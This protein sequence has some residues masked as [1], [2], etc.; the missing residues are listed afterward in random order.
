[1]LGISWRKWFRTPVKRSRKGGDARARSRRLLLEALEDRFLPA[2]SAF[3]SMPTNLIASQGGI[4]NV[5]VSIDQL[6]AGNAQNHDQGLHSAT[7][8]LTYDTNVFTVS[9]ADVSQGA[10]LTNPPPNG[11]WS[12]TVNTSTAGEIDVTAS[13]AA[14]LSQDILGQTGG[15]FANISFHVKATAPT[16]STGLHIVVPNATSPNGLSS[17]AMPNSGPH[18]IQG[19]AQGYKLFT[20]DQVD[21]VVTV[22]GPAT[23][24]T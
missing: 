4:V 15:I 11:N 22:S 1:M 24:F 19:N 8:V 12:F 9:N 14:N 7:L 6:S 21:G 5:P 23:H 20:A 18:S 13:G 16:A 3:F 2:Q 17:A 10:L